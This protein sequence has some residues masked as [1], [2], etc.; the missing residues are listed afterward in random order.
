VV[1]HARSGKPQA[2]HLC[3][4]GRRGVTTSGEV[5][6]AGQDITRL[7]E[8]KIARIRGGRIGLIFQDP[9]SSLNPVQRI[10]TQIGEVLRLHRVSTVSKAR[11]TRKAGTE[12]SS[13]GIRR[14][15]E[16]SAFADGFVT[17]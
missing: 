17:G 4:S 10:G 14:A 3:K 9:T 8:R 5:L 11:T 2:N 6:L 16:G 1:A 15:V 13:V 7:S 12:T